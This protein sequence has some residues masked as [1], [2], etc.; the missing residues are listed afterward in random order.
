MAGWIVYALTANVLWGVVGLLQ[1][2]G[3]NRISAESLV[4]W[5]TVGY[6]LLLPGFLMACSITTLPARAVFLGLLVGITNGLGAWFLFA[7]LENGGKASVV[8]PMTALYPFL[9]VLLATTFL[10]ESLVP[11]QWIGI[12]LAMVSAV[13]ISCESPQRAGSQK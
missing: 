2:L 7:A 9:T 5:L 1:K 12:I 11:R 8:V 10:G 4:V 3:T 13:L 6:M